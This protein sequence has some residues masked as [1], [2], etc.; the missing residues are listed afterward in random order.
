MSLRPNISNNSFWSMRA[1]EALAVLETSQDGLN[2]NEAEARK[3]VFGPNILKEE[4]HF[5]QLRIFLRQ[6]GSPLI[7]ILVFAGG[8]TIFLKDY[9]DAAVIF[10]AVIVNTLLGFYQESKAESAIKKLAAYIVRMVRVIRGGKEIKIGAEELVPGDMVRLNQGDQIPADCRLLYAN[11]L[12]VDEAII[13]GESL[14]VS[15]TPEPVAVSAGLSDQ[16]SMVFAGTSITQGVAM[17]VVCRI[18]KATEIGK[19]AEMVSLAKGDT[20]PLQVAIKRFSFGAAL[21]LGML[22][23]AVFSMGI[24]VGTPALEMLIISVAMAVGAV[25]EGLPIALTVILAVHVQRLSRRRG[26]IRKLLAAETLGST[27]VILTDKTGTLTEAKMNLSKIISFDKNLSENDLLALSLLNTNVLIENEEASPEHWELSGRALEIALV[28]SA[29]KRNIFAGN[30][31]KNVKILSEM[32]FNSKNKF[33]AVY[34]HRNKN[35]E[36]LFLGAP[37]V[38]LKRSSHLANEKLEHDRGQEILELISEMAYGGERV[39]GVAIKKGNYMKDFSFSDKNAAIELNFLGLISFRDPVRAG[40][41]GALKKV[42]EY[43]VKTVIVTGDHKGTAESVAREIGFELDRESVIDD[44][45]FSSMSEEELKDRLPLIK[46]FARVS[47]E[48]KLKIAKAYQEVGEVVA[49]T[50]DGVNDAPSLKQADIGIAMGT[51]VDVTK[52]IAELVILDDNFETIVAAIEEGRKMMGNL[53]KVM[54]Y[55]LSSVFD[56]LFLIG[57]AILSGLTI[58]ITAAQILWVNFFTDSF[59]AIALAFENDGS[60]IGNHPKKVPKGMLD[61][62]M[63]FLILVIG[64]ASSAFLFLTYYALLNF[65]TLDEGLVRTFIFASFGLYSIFLVLSVRSLKQSIFAYGILSNRYMLLSIFIGTIMMLFGIYFG[66]LQ[67][68]MG[69]ED[70]PAVWM[71][72][73]GAIALLNIAAIEVGK[74]IY[75]KREF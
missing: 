75:R 4:K 57:G 73:V 8:L 43:G 9:K 18:G 27:S 36:V 58:P 51:G 5:A 42:T 15:K 33:S 12:L 46:V 59:P 21:I 71:L 16:N 60:D 22:I 69:T 68:F 67:S 25:P 48:D 56:E 39:L 49:M 6:F 37:D 44:G 26:I 35:H 3:K 32:P 70:L 40:I 45:E 53:R 66:P 55:L 50:G 61:A 72:G 34:F 47:P 10:A 54:V 63:K 28:L 62:E 2:S 41:V 1:E 38:L 65:F 74:H 13:T 19:I 11:D 20:T 17:A 31:K 30:I 29:A 24:Y 23:L 7:L 52:E 64:V 14:P